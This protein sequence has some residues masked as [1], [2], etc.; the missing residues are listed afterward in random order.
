MT[1]IE[2]TGALLISIIVSARRPLTVSEFESDFE[3]LTGR[4]LKTSDKWPWHQ[5]DKFWHDYSAYIHKTPNG[6]IVAKSNDNN[7][8]IYTVLLHS[9][10]IENIGHWLAW[11]KTQRRATIFQWAKRWRSHSFPYFQQPRNAS[12]QHESKIRLTQQLATIGSHPRSRHW[13]PKMKTIKSHCRL[14]EGE[15]WCRAI[16]CTVFRNHSF[17]QSKE[18]NDT[19]ALPLSLRRS[20]SLETIA[21]GEI[22]D[23]NV[24]LYD[25]IDECR[26]DVSWKKHLVRMNIMDLI[27]QFPN[28]VKRRQFWIQDRMAPTFFSKILGQNFVVKY[29]RLKFWF[30]AI[31]GK[32]NAKYPESAE[33]VNNSLTFIKRRTKQI[34]FIKT[35]G[36][37]IIKTKPCTNSKVIVRPFYRLLKDANYEKAIYEA[38]AKMVRDG[39]RRLVRMMKIFGHGIFQ[40]DI[41]G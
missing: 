25:D 22:N 17:T 14:Q 30:E 20:S 12:N 2:E 38:T 7:R 41:D 10:C 21:A 15:N 32:L 4:K 6:L 5:S 35:E 28:G 33:F 34:M 8:Y 18:L 29:L 40:D 11:L 37:T 16:L 36:S 39:Y 31:L 9:T 27:F 3:S 1:D 23:D 19:E 13:Y 26:E 24:E